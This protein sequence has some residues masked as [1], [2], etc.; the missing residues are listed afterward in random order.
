MLYPN[1]NPASGIELHLTASGSD[2]KGGQVKVLG[3]INGR[4]VLRLDDRTDGKG[5]VYFVIDIPRNAKSVKMKV[6]LLDYFPVLNSRMY[7]A[8]GR[9]N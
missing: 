7:R 9:S 6:S 3:K 8:G 1:R 5:V 4:T 2:S